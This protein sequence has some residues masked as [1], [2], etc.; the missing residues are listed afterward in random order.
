MS[1]EF[2]GEHVDN[3]FPH[4][5]TLGKGGEGEV[6]RVDLPQSWNRNTNIQRRGHH[7]GESTCR[8]A[9]TFAEGAPDRLASWKGNCKSDFWILLSDL[10]Q[11]F[12]AFSKRF[13]EK[14]RKGKIV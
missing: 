9:G 13:L 14:G 5:P 3:L 8:S 12:Y 10:R 6:V 4:P 11:N 1:P 2:P 7:S